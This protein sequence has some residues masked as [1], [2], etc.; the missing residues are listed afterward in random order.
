MCVGK[1]G[2]RHNFSETKL[3]VEKGPMSYGVYNAMVIS[4]RGS[5]WLGESRLFREFTEL[6][7]EEGFILSHRYH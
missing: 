2:L 1:E 3:F 5:R 4:G 7:V 6:E